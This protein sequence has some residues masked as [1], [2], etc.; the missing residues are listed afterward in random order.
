MYKYGYSSSSSNNSN[1]SNNRINKSNYNFK[2]I[3][4]S[5]VVIMS[6][7]NNN[8]NYNNCINNSYRATMVYTVELKQ[9]TITVLVKSFM[10][11]CNCWYIENNSFVP[12]WL[13]QA[14]LMEV[15]TENISRQQLACEIPICDYRTSVDSEVVK[16]IKHA[17]FS[18]KIE[19]H[20]V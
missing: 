14:K 10:R 18:F 6:N 1:S 20:F 11:Q 5:T 3:N 4:T 12:R 2:R 19:F 9:M 7:D 13:F 8:N 15:E 17:I 16:L